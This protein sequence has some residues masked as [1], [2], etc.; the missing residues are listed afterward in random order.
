MCQQVCC[1]CRETGPRCPVD[2]SK[3]LSSQVCECVCCAWVC[4]YNEDYLGP[5]NSV[6]IIKW[7]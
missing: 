4:M 6:L 2:N 3:V 1:V 5:S 7:S